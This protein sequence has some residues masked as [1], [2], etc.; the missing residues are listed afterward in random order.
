MKLKEV[1]RDFQ[2]KVKKKSFNTIIK[3]PKKKTQTFWKWRMEKKLLVDLIT[4]SIIAASLNRLKE[5]DRQPYCIINVLRFQVS[6]PLVRFSAFIYIIINFSK[7]I[8]ML[9]WGF[10]ISS[11]L[12]FKVLH[13]VAQCQ[14]LFKSPESYHHPHS[15][16]Y[17]I[18]IYLLLRC[19]EKQ[20][21]I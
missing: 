8:L 6:V 17:L 1:F 16:V 7:I 19:F 4:H 9:F 13:V 21:C 15:I 11:I 20:V 14:F 3:N 18:C 12:V 2:I 5:R 10:F